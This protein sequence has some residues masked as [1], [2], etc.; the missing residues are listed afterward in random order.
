MSRGL[1]DVYKR[2]AIQ[3]SD[4][5]SWQR[6]WSNSTSAVD[7]FRFWQEKLQSARPV[8]ADT[9]YGS[10]DTQDGG[11]A[12]A[13][14]EFTGELFNNIRDLSRSNE[15][16]IFITLLAGFMGVLHQ[17][18]GLTDL[19]VGTAM[20]NRRIPSIDKMMG[21]V[22][23]TVLVRTRL[24]GNQ[25]GNELLQAV[26]ETLLEAFSYQELPFE[27]LAS[28]LKTK[29]DIDVR[30][31]LDVF[32]VNQ[33]PYRSPFQLPGL[34]TTG[35]GDVYREG[36]PAMPINRSRMRIMLKETSDGVIGSCAYRQDCFSKPVIEQLLTEYRQILVQMVER[37]ETPIKSFIFQ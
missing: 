9:A 29:S 34:Q 36:Q 37:P 4:F 12:Y 31:L 22:E 18:T 30:P 10:S 17:A 25:T 3:F 24:A 2:Q 26:R 15:C 23:N 6:Q 35:F 28:Q 13:P 5:A 20:A 32:F 11:L 1:G 7:Q 16:T 8:F 33:N 21:L 14:V 27:L 19:C